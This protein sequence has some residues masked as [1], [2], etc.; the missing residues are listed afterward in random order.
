MTPFMYV[1]KARIHFD[2]S[3]DKLKL[4]IVVRGDLQNKDLIRDTWSAIAS[5]KTLR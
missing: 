4:I 1:Y 3:T 2:G 5:M